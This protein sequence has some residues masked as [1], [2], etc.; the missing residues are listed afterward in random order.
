MTELI[1][2][3]EQ[4]RNICKPRTA[5]SLTS[6]HLDSVHSTYHQDLHA[7]FR[8]WCLRSK[9]EGA[10]NQ[11]H[12]GHELTDRNWKRQAGT[13][14]RRAEIEDRQA[15]GGKGQGWGRST[16]HVNLFSQEEQEAEKSLGQNVEYER[17]KKEQELLAQQRTGLA[18]TVFGEGS[19]ELTKN[20]QPWYKYVASPSGESKAG[21]SAIRLG[22]EVVRHEAEA[23]LKRD[24]G[25]KA[26]GDPM[27]SLFRSAAQP[28]SMGN[29][30][31][32]MSSETDEALCSSLITGKFDEESRSEPSVERR[33]R[34]ER[35]KDKKRG[36]KRKNK[37]ESSKR[38]SSRRCP[39]KASG[40]K[41]DSD[42]DASRESDDTRPYLVRSAALSLPQ[43]PNNETSE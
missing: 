33:H 8:P 14:G 40:S 12:A 42:Q 36:K 34:G 13:T 31:I 43:R 3:H 38:K 20:R 17:E 22:R 29:A 28:D 7:G 5:T 25:R 26:L 41:S 30:R 23:V 16:E 11:A 15:L 27:G 6:W 35:H 18:P 39:R 4:S 21:A 9:N 2:S 10:Q 37:T 19:A 1:S 32:K 24:Q